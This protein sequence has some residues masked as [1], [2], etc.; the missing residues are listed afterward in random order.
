MNR[1]V[2]V[3]IHERLAVQ[4]PSKLA[5]VPGVGVEPLTLL[6]PRLLLILRINKNSYTRNPPNRGTASTREW[7]SQCHPS[8]RFAESAELGASPRARIANS[9]EARRFS[10]LSFLQ[11]IWN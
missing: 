7:L 4:F 8:R 11:K 10:P 3:R 2:Q 5:L 9:D 1:E 6:K